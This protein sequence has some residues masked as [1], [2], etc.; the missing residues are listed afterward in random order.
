MKNKHRLIALCFAAKG[1]QLYLHS[2]MEGSQTDRLPRCSADG[3][4]MY[5]YLTH[6]NEKKLSRNS[7]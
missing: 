7:L 6:G 4:R 1:E 2:E 3:R 5:S